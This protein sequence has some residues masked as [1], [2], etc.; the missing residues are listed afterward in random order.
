MSASGVIVPFLPPISPF[1]MPKEPMNALFAAYGIDLQ[2]QRSHLCPCTYG[3]PITGSP[4]PAC[5]TCFGRGWYWDAPSATFRG[6][7]TF[8]HLSPTPDEPGAQMSDKFGMNLQSSPT[9]TIPDTATPAWDQASMN[10]VFVEI[11]AIDRFEAQLQVGGVTAL[12][13]E[14]ELNVPVSGAVTIYDTLTNQVVQVSG[15][16]VSGAVVTLPSGYVSGTPYIVSYAAAKAYAAWRE[17]GAMPHSRPFGNIRL[18]RRFRLQA[19]DLW[20]R[21]S[22]KI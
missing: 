11:G 1:I 10:D 2:W 18:P 4:D 14:Q 12:P 5:L 21:G 8:M 6:L 7:I 20:L 16:V 19:L 3:G 22:G 9:L 15:Y 17:A 13:Y